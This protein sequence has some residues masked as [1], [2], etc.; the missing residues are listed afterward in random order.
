MLTSSGAKVLDFG[1]AKLIAPRAERRVRPPRRSAE[2]TR[3]GLVVG[4]AGY[5]SPEQARGEP[6]DTRA[7]I[8]AF[9]CVLF[10]MLS[11]R[12]AFTRDSVAET[13][14]AVLER[15][16][17]WTLVPSTTP[18]VAAAGGAAVPAEGSGAPAPG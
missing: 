12:A 8:W 2:E 4:T 1:L 10:E 17:D 6:V 18:L 15:E 16:P 5:M 9:G 3:Q 11:G 13:M 7:D 14:V